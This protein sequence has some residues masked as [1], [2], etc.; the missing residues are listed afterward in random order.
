MNITKSLRNLF[1]R[2]SANGS[3]CHFFS[4]TKGAEKEKLPP[5]NRTVRLMTDAVAE[6]SLGN[7]TC[8]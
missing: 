1:E 3:F 8:M 5:I 2:I 6:F 4:T 7:R